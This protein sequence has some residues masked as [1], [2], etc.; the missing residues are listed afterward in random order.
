MQNRLN[1]PLFEPRMINYPSKTV[2]AIVAHLRGQTTNRCTLFWEIDN[3]RDH[4]CF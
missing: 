4:S 1:K 3:P 2:K